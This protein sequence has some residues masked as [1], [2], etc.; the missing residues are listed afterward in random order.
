MRALR[1]SRLRDWPVTVPSVNE[2]AIWLDLVEG[3]GELASNLPKWRSGRTITT[4]RF[5]ELWGAYFDFVPEAER[6]PTPEVMLYAVAVFTELF[7]KCSRE[8]R[9]L[10]FIAPDPAF[11]RH[12]WDLQHRKLSA[13]AKPLRFG[14][15][16]WMPSLE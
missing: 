12:W 8:N 4:A 14:T 11:Y 10:T 13:G 9:N 1:A 7:V 5:A 16:K 3:C 6:P 15:K 2:M